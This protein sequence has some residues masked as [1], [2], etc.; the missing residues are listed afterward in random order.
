MG[1]A[2][3][4]LCLVKKQPQYLHPA[5]KEEYCPYFMDEGDVAQIPAKRRA[6][7][8]RLRREIFEADIIISASGWE[9]DIYDDCGND[10]SVDIDGVDWARHIGVSFDVLAVQKVQK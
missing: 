2:A 10:G 3:V 5:N 7:H 8:L 1:I 9:E 6:E 4:G